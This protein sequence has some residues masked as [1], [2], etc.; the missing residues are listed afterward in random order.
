ME[1]NIIRLTEQDLHNLIKESVEQVLLENSEQELDEGFGDFIRSFAGQYG[2]RGANQMQQGM[3]N[4]GNTMQQGY[5]AAKQ[6]MKHVGNK[7]AQGYNAAKQGMQNVGN[8]IQQGYNNVKSDIQQTAQNAK[9]D[10]SMRDMQKAFDAFK[11]AVEKYKAAG[12]TVNRQLGSRM[13]GIDKMI[14]GY[15]AHY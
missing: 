7:M 5:N 9:Q 3:Q 1:K 4:V 10:S 14:N 15:E 12:G 2:K 11:M 13:A 6:G 8:K